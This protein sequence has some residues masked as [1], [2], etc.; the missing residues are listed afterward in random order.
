V[1]CKNLIAAKQFRKKVSQPFFEIQYEIQAK[2]L[3]KLVQGL[4]LNCNEILTK[5]MGN[6]TTFF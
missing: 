4:P 6:V 3:P 1:F 2:M 5:K